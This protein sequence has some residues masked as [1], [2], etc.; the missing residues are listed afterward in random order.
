MFDPGD[1]WE[2]GINIDW[3]G[4]LV[5]EVS[6]QKLD[7]YFA[8]RITG[9]LG[10]KDT[11]FVVSA[12]QRA[13]Q[14]SVH[15]RDNEGTLTPQPFETPTEREFLAG[16]GGLYSTAGDYLAFLRALLSGGG[17]IIKPAT[18]SANGREPYPRAAGRHPQDQ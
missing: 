1:R 5:E 3:I 6:G 2:Y 12:E 11:G 16:G 4:R 10:M 9:P 14:A 8:E 15:Q 17:G 7:V 18:V 13:R